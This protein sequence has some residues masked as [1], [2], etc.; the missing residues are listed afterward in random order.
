MPY[1]NV[2]DRKAYEERNK[3]KLRAYRKKYYQAHKTK[4]NKQNKEYYEKHKD[5]IS[6]QTKKY[7]S[8]HREAIVLWRRKHYEENKEKILERNKKYREAN[9]DRL[10]RLGVEYHRKRKRTHYGQVHSAIS[11]AIHN[12]RMT[13]QPCEVCGAEPAEAH[14]DDYNKPLEVRWLCD[15]HHKEWHKY[16][17]PKYIKGAE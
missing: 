8:D 5:A 16:N 13:K 2:E 4:L 10:L 1:K 11:N 17:K 14:H 3:E 7:K 9:K 12:G 6:Q 15:K